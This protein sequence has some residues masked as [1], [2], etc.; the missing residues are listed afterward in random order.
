LVIGSVEISHG[1]LEVSL[2]SLHFIVYLLK[3][4]SQH[5]SKEKQNAKKQLEKQIVLIKTTK[6]DTINKS[7][8][9]YLNEFKRVLHCYKTFVRGFCLF[10][11]GL[12]T[13]SAS[14]GFPIISLRKCVLA[15]PV[16]SP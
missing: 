8:K 5:I 13:L 9:K 2:S 1:L 12:R 4:V 11:V 16:F 7:M 3:I 15:M 6:S 14:R 10:C